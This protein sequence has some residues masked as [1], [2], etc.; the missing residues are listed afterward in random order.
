[1][2]NKQLTSCFLTGRS[3][4]F[5]AASSIEGL[6][7]ET[8]KSPESNAVRESRGC[9]GVMEEMEVGGGRIA[10][11][12]SED[13]ESVK[14][15]VGLL[16]RF[17]VLPSSTEATASLSAL[18]LAYEVDATG[19]GGDI[20]LPFGFLLCNVLSIARSFSSCS[21]RMLSKKSPRRTR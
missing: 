11:H 21:R 15:G 6:E 1:M 13:E 14:V 19:G 5:V 7:K 2:N 12:S 10:H 8:H 4:S 20:E 17:L 3:S 16:L 9:G 18:R